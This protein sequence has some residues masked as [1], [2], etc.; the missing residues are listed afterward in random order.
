MH[1]PSFVQNDAYARCDRNQIIQ[2]VC[3]E[4]VDKSFKISQLECKFE[5]ITDHDVYAKRGQMR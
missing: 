4:S 2:H 5:H 3:I 1:G